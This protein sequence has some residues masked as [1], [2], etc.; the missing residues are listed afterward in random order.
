MASSGML[1]RV[2][3]VRTDVS[4][5]LSASII[6]VTRIGELGTTLAV[7]SNR[8]MLRR[9]ISLQEPRGV[10]SP[11]TPFLIVTAVKT[12]KCYFSVLF[13]GLK[14][15]PNNKDV[16]NAEYI[17]QCKIKFEPPEHKKDIYIYI[18][19]RFHKSKLASRPMR[20]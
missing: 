18:Y 7:T 6:R 16:F 17:Q 2:A 8:R 9:N 13:V 20:K 10:T 19:F 3:L 5:E 4:E 1:R 14:P 12:L 15:A 11:K